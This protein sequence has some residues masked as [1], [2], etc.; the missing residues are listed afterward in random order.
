[1]CEIQFSWMN[2]SLND[3]DSCLTKPD[4]AVLVLFLLCSEIII[5]IDQWNFCDVIA[6]CLG[7]KGGKN[8][9]GREYIFFNS[10]ESILTQTQ[11]ISCYLTKPHQTATTTKNG[12][13]KST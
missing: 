1:M 10:K 8:A 2:H 6:Y 13:T 9:H 3:V 5:A 7:V 11:S 4:I 12:N